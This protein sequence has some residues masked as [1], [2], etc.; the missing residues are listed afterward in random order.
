MIRYLYEFHY[1]IAKQMITVG[2]SPFKIE[3]GNCIC[4]PF[5]QGF[6]E[7]FSQGFSQG[8]SLGAC[9]LELSE[10]FFDVSEE[11]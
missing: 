6:S 11:T 3:I 10:T 8:F 9:S 4:E 7:G 5:S 2:S 1:L